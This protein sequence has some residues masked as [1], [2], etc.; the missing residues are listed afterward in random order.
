M[1]VVEQDRQLRPLLARALAAAGYE[2]VTADTRAAAIARVE[3][4]G[5]EPPAVLVTCLHLPDASGELLAD[6]LEAL[7]PGLRTLFVSGS[8]VNDG[9][10]HRGR[11][12]LRKPF[13]PS[14]LRAS[15]AAL[16]AARSI[17]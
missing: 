5:A 11:P 12:A 14:L 3:A 17:G 7:V 4:R 9:G 2:V 10:L 16:L 1:L 13:A 8:F 6:E 15:L